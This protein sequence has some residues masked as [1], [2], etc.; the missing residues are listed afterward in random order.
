MAVIK[1]I[2]TKDYVN[3]DAGRSELFIKSGRASGYL[4]ELN[5]F[6]C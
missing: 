3:L 4:S 2:E 5:Y 1:V 6:P